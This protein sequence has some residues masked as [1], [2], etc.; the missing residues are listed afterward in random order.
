MLGVGSGESAGGD[1]DDNG[2]GIVMNHA[3][4]IL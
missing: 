2:R 3:Y 4:A 1:N